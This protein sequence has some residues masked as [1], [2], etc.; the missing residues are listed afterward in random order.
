MKEHDSNSP[1]RGALD[2]RGFLATTATALTA[3]A[4]ALT[5]TKGTPRDWTGKTPTRYPEPDV[6]V[7]DL[8]N[9]VASVC[10]A[11]VQN[12]RSAHTSSTVLI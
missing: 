4:T 6:L 2:R 12:A 7:L 10:K 8:P 11:G 5:A 1:S 3:T 9:L